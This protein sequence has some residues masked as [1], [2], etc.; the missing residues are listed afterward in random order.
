MNLRAVVKDM[1]PPVA[2]RAYSK[3]R[4][5][6]L[7]FG[8][9]PKDWVEAESLST[10][11]SASDILDR[12]RIATRA[13]VE[14]RSAYERD[15]VLFDEPDYAFPLITG[16]LRAAANADMQLDVVDFGGSLGST[17]RQCRPLLDTVQHLQWHILEQPHFVEAG[18]QEFETDELH[19][20]QDL[21]DIPPPKWA[22]ALL[23]SGVLQ[24]LEKPCEILAELCALPGRH[25]IIDR[26]PVN[27][28]VSDRL[29]IQTVPPR[30][31]SAS[32]PCWLLSKK[33]LLDTLAK[34]WRL[35]Y[36]FP[37]LDGL[38]TTDD[39]LPFEFRGFL[40]DRLV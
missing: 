15:S 9:F 7:R 19:F 6:M 31:Y 5:Q 37:C 11:Y 39:G 38:M 20:W 16:L 34:D 14:G 12:V 35:V 27:A 13:V 33:K 4:G 32:Y 28:T 22:Q 25:L 21:K 17:Y 40:L 2:L 1:V 23:L 10:G 18:R 3:W 8:G 29:L 26:L 36:E 30:I 24:Y